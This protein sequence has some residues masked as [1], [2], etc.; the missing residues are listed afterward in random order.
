MLISPFESTRFLYSG[1]CKDLLCQKLWPKGPFESGNRLDVAP[2]TLPAQI[3]G[4]PPHC[5]AMHDELSSSRQAA[6]CFH[7]PN[8]AAVQDRTIDTASRDYVVAPV[9]G[10]H[11]FSNPL[12]EDASNTFM[13]AFYINYYFKLIQSFL[14]EGLPMSAATNKKAMASYTTLLVR[15]DSGKQSDASWP[16]TLESCRKSLKRD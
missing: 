7:L 16:N 11:M 6:I 14:N 10:Q 9:R 5:H 2:F 4:P 8:K 12:D 13:P 1:F 3:S 15:S